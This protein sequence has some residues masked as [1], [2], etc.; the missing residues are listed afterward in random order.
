M[1]KIAVYACDLR[2]S[3]SLAEYLVQWNDGERSWVPCSQLFHCSDTDGAVQL[4][5]PLTSNVM[6]RK[7]WRPVLS[8]NK[9]AA[10]LLLHYEGQT[11]INIDT[12]LSLCDLSIV[13]RVKMVCN[14]IEGRLIITSRRQWLDVHP[15]KWESEAGKR[16]AHMAFLAL[17][18]KEVLPKPQP[19]DSHMRA[20]DFFASASDC[21]VQ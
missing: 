1:P 18:K 14:A 7:A 10:R 16:L 19:T 4:Y 5:K 3:E 11:Q 17:K 9:A 12:I 6:P 8:E 15:D 21:V 2:T 13:E 20:D